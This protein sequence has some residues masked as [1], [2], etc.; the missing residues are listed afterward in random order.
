MSRKLIGFRLDEE[1]AKQL[2][3]YAIENNTSI[4][5]LLEDFVKQLLNKKV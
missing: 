1:I 2:Q 5:K 3:I 4:Q